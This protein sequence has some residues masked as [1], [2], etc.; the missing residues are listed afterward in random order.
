MSVK[1]A[2]AIDLTLLRASFSE[3]NLKPPQCFHQLS[4]IIWRAQFIYQSLFKHQRFW[5]RY[6]EFNNLTF[7]G[8]FH[9]LY[10][11]CIFPIWWI[12]R[13]TYRMGGLKYI[14]QYENGPLLYF[15]STVQ[16]VLTMDEVNGIRMSS[17]WICITILIPPPPPPPPRLKNQYI[18]FD[19]I[20][21]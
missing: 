10:L 15:V 2:P 19:L 18:W 20:S 1:G 11:F 16:C 5:K 12:L 3:G 13:H 9:G 8:F 6:M 4:T 7:V 17:L 14:C 21:R